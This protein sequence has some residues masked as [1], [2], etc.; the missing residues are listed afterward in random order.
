M[1][2]L[3]IATWFVS[4][5][6]PN[7]AIWIKRHLESLETH[8][9]EQFVVH[10]EVIGGEKF[11]F[12]KKDWKKGFQ[13]KLT[14]PSRSWFL[15]ELLTSVLLF[16][17]LKKVGLHRFDIVNF[18]IAYPTL[19]Y[20]H[21]IKR[22]FSI[23]VVI[24]EHWSAY[25]F[26]FG[27]DKPLP[28]VQRIF[29]QNIPVITVSNSLA[30]DIRK[31]ANSEF[32]RFIIPNVVEASIYSPNLSVER[33]NEFFMVSQ[34]NWPKRPM[35][36]LEA[37]AE[38]I[39]THPDFKL[40]IGG[41]GMDYQAIRNWIKQNQMDGKVL[42]LGRL[43]AEEV[44]NELMRCK[45]FIHCSEYETFSV[46]CAE[47]VS[48]HTP[49]IASRVGG[50]VEVVSEKEGILLESMNTHDWSNAMKEAIHRRFHFR[51]NRFTKARVG[52]MYYNVLLKVRDG[53]S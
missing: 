8:V 11:K 46:V 31:F 34:W 16:C 10:L 24:T 51:D 30:A 14:V 28:R 37:F 18:H 43:Q 33:E 19:T 44:A 23:P 2:V 12:Y 29:R 38:L 7:K 49:V 1:K 26:N 52:E 15:L 20:W 41:Y 50:I 42:L 9:Q 47:A 3:H 27:V 39:K 32:Q 6:D 5:Q 4:E 17:Y 45:A 13:R 22:F 48:C 21:I 25:H 40:K 36:V 53:I 35:V